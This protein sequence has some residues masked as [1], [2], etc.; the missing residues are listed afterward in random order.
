[1]K[2]KIIIIILLAL[3]GIASFATVYYSLKNTL[4][5]N[6]YYYPQISETTFEFSGKSKH[7]SFEIGKVYFDGERQ[8]ILIDNFMQDVK[9][10]NLQEETVS[11]LFDD[12][13]W[14]SIKNDEQLNKI[15]KV[16]KNIRFYESGIL[17]NDDS[18]IQCEKT[19]FNTLVTHENFKKI[20]E[21][22]VKY[23]LT[24]GNCYTEKFEIIYK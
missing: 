5:T 10:K 13:E 3:L 21:I 17:C 7:F 22:S 20:F 4:D 14:I 8:E 12:K 2:K 1:M 9:I 24:N 11:V 18:S 16:I 15:G 6:N 19:V 23:C